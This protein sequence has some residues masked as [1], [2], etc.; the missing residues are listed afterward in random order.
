MDENAARKIDS[1]AALA[2][3]AKYWRMPKGRF[4][5]VRLHDGWWYVGSDPWFDCGYCKLVV[6]DTVEFDGCPG[7]EL[8]MHRERQER[9]VWERLDAMIQ[10]SGGRVH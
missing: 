9:D 10:A 2:V 8:A 5:P 3:D 6:F 7:C 4:V 1:K